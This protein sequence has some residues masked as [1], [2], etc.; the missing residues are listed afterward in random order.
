MFYPTIYPMIPRE[1][2]AFLVLLSGWWN[3]E[4]VE[5]KNRWN[6]LNVPHKYDVKKYTGI[7]IY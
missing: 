5:E 6:F 2:I 7:K 3:S 4:I 1:Y